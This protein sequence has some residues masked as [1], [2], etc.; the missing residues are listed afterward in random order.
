[1]RYISA[2]AESDSRSSSQYF[3]AIYFFLSSLFTK[4]SVQGEQM[5]NGRT[6]A[7]RLTT[8][9]RGP[10][11]DS[12][13]KIHQNRKAIVRMNN[14]NRAKRGYGKKKKK[15]TEIGVRLEPNIASAGNRL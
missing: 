8:R 12:T 15:K 5:I 1:M 2:L 9:P 3:F 13:I 4:H 7:S 14:K 6:G 11:Q 10:H